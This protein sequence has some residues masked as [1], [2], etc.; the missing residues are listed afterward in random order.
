MIAAVAILSATL[1][2]PREI[3]ALADIGAKGAVI[4]IE[5]GTCAE[6][7]AR[8]AFP[9]NRFVEYANAHDAIVALE[10][11]KVDALVYD[12]PY[13]DYAALNRPGIRVLDENLGASC[14]SIGAPFGR[15]A[16]ME[17][18]NAYIRSFRADGT[19]DA[20]YRRWVLTADPEMPTI[21]EP[22]HPDGTIRIGITLDQMP[23][24]YLAEG[25]GY[26]GYDIEF[27]RRLALYLNRRIEFL[28]MDYP[29]L[30]AATS[31]GKVELGISQFDATEERR[32][33]MLLSDPYIDSPVGVAV[34]RAGRCRQSCSDWLI[35]GFRRTF[36]E[37][38]RW[39]LL[40]DGLAVTLEI[41]FAAALLG[42]V[43]AFPLWLALA[44]RIRPIRAMGRAWV[45]V[46]QGTPVLVMLMIVFYVAFSDIDISPVLVAVLVFGCHFSAYAGEMLLSGIMAVPRG[47]WEAAS[48]LGYSQAGA[49][50]RFVFPQVLRI[51]LPVYRGTL[52]SMLKDT[53]VVGYITIHDLTKVGDLVRARTYDGF[54][55]LVS[56]AIVYFLL[57][58]L[59]A[60][61]LKRA[62][63]CLGPRTKGANRTCP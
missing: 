56:T 38:A 49:F 14:I 17:K 8:L 48:A 60:L 63:D 28:S 35:G 2:A 30:I 33:A 9:K 57:A 24:G 34:R 53:S 21:P 11:G 15:D 43:L 1:V 41:T 25:G 52:I 39:K 10:G 22:A 55:P 3:Q 62:G 16:L 12:R 46:M 36:V 20:M 26:E 40:L 6:R 23:M 5:E 50:R 7:Q 42:T 13:L 51:V 54:F 4:A 44:S 31:A 18:V 32:K 27:S 58:K 61:A 45:E 47:Q 19:Y 29:A 59:M 37:E